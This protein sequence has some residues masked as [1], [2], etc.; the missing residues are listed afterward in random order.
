MTSWCHY[1]FLVSLSAIEHFGLGYYGEAVGAQGDYEAMKLAYA[2]LKPE[3]R[4]TVL[5][6]RGMSRITGDAVIRSIFNS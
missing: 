6:A 3:G 4:F 2:W 1:D 5:L